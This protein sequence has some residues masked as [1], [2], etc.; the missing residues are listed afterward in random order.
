MVDTNM[1]TI[2]AG[3]G[4]WTELELSSQHPLL[5]IEYYQDTAGRDGFRPYRPPAPGRDAKT[6]S[7]EHLDMNS[8]RCSARLGAV[9]LVSL[10]GA[11]VILDSSTGACSPHDQ[12]P[13]Y[14][15]TA[16]F[17]P[18]A[19]IAALGGAPPATI[20]KPTTGVVS[21]QALGWHTLKVGYEHRAALT[22]TAAALSESTQRGVT[23][24][25]FVPRPPARGS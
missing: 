17:V 15:R 10:S 16:F 5:I 11:S 3:P 20:S 25:Y 1:V 2:I 14:Y 4:A 19:M 21:L 12:S 22:P 18:P 8:T 9:R 6:I 24:Q 23:S 13:G 7:L